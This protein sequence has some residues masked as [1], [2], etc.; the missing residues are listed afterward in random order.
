MRTDMNNLSNHEV[1]RS[2]E[3]LQSVS[4][5]IRIVALASVE[6]R[7][8]EST[9]LSLTEKVQVGSTS[10][11]LLAIAT[12]MANYVHFGTA[13]HAHLKGEIGSILLVRVGTKAVLT[14]IVDGNANHS[15][16][17]LESQKLASRLSFLI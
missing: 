1:V 4:T 7:I 17:M 8:L 5:D 12:K 2:L 16:I 13:S 6:G 15:S 3:V 11:A 14:V 10:A 9:P